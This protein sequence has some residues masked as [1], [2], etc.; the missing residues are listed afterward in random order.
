MLVVMCSAN[1]CLFLQKK[2]RMDFGELKAL[3]TM[4]TIIGPIL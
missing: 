1:T 4:L 3:L 2:T